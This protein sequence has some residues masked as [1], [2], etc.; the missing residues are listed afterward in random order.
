MNPIER[1][2]LDLLKKMKNECGALAV[3]AEFEAEGIRTQELVMLNEVVLRADMTLIVKIGGCEAVRDLDECRMLGA[4]GIIAPMV[5]TP[6]AMKK[7]SEAAN[8]V[9]QEQAGDIEWIINAETVTSHQNLDEILNVGAGF[10]NTVTIGRDDYAGSIGL[11]RAELNG[12]RMLERT[13]DIA[14]RVKACGCHVGLGGG[15]SV[16]AI[17]FLRRMDGYIDKFETRK[18]AFAAGADEGCLRD[19]ITSAIEFEM[20]Y[21]QNK[22]GY[23]GRM[24]RED[25]GRLDEMRRRLGESAGR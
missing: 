5:E 12:E 23:Y 15:I 13:L 3:K 14:R 6:Y 24:A 16:N 21:L 9:Y 8:R 20:L 25:E 17:P 18:V 10:L 4:G 22:C 19:G 7:F 11:D 1:K 2:M